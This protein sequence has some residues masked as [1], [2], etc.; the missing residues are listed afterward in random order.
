MFGGNVYHYYLSFRP[1]LERFCLRDFHARR[2]H[3]LL[4]VRQRLAYDGLKRQLFRLGNAELQNFQRHIV[5]VRFHSRLRMFN[6]VV[7]NLSFRPILERE[8]VR[9]EYLY[10]CL[11]LQWRLRFRRIHWFLPC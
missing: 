7:S 9:N 11:Q 2:H 6:V 3:R 4:S 1:V 10:H 8:R 5:F